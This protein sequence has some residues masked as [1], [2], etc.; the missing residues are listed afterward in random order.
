MA[1]EQQKT[2]QELFLSAILKTCHALASLGQLP[3]SLA[4]LYMQQDHT[5]DAI[6]ESSVAESLQ[7]LATLNSNQ[8]LK[9]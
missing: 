1:R 4:D 5:V 2:I 7:L 3:L 9:D 6:L 8:E